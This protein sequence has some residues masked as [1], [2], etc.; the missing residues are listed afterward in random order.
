MTKINIP[1]GL[2]LDPLRL[3]H[4]LLNIK[5]DVPMMIEIMKKNIDVI[6]N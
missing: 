6:S 3:P 4:H 2:L 1:E 5:E